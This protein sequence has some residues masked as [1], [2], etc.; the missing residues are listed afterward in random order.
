MAKSMKLAR[1]LI[2]GRDAFKVLAVKNSTVYKPGA[3]LSKNEVDDLIEYGQW[4]IDIVEY[5]DK[6]GAL[7]QRIRKLEEASKTK[8]TGETQ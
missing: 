1:G 5:T 4:T 2:G 6:H 8:C 7:E 3:I